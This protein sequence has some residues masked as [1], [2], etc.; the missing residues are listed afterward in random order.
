[1]VKWLEGREGKG[2]ERKGKESK[3]P[4]IWKVFPDDL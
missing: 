4:E 3:W 1:M 2:N